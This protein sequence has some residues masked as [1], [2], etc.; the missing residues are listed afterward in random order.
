MVGLIDST[1]KVV[2]TGTEGEIDNLEIEGLDFKRTDDG[3][4][5][6]FQV[7]DIF[8]AVVDELDTIKQARNL[9]RNDVNNSVIIVYEA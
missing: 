4:E 1:N 2:F 8:G 6:V 7:L 9:L 5:R 3:V